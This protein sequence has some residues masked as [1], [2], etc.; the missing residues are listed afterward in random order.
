MRIHLTM[1]QI[2]K[3]GVDFISE[4]KCPSTTLV[5]IFVRKV[6]GEQMRLEICFD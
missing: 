6:F 1:Y 2:L 3:K 5:T 4:S